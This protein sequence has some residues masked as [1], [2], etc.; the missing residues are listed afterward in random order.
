MFATPSTFASP[1]LALDPARQF[2]KAALHTAVTLNTSAS[3]DSPFVG[4]TVLDPETKGAL[5]PPRY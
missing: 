4:P 5:L 2:L 3:L 1:Q